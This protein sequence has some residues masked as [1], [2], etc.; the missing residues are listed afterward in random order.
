MI[1]LVLGAFLLLVVSGVAV[2]YA[3][4][5][6]SVLS[7]IATDN[8][9]YLAI[10]PQNFFS[11]IDVFA[12]MAMPL[13]ILTGE[14]MNRAGITKALID[15]AMAMM[16][17]IKGGLGHVNVLA[18]V[19]LSGIS[20]SAVA[21]AA[22]LGKTV[23]P[24]M[25][26]RGYSNLYASALTAAA[27][28]IGPIIPPSIIM[29]FYG[30][31]MQ[32]SVSAM[33]IGGVIPGLLL[34]FALFGANSYFAYRYNHPGGRRDELPRFWPSFLHAAP[35]LSLPAIILGGIVFGVVTPTEAAAL[36][37]VAAIVIGIYYGGLN[38]SELR[39]ALTQ[40]A[41]LTGTIF[42]ILGA[43]AAFGWLA[44]YLSLPQLLGSSVRDL[45]LGKW[46][47][48]VLI[49]IVFFVAGTFFEPPV[50]LALLVPLLG[51]QALALG[52]DPVHLGIILSLNLTL[53]MITP[54]LGGCLLVVSAVTQVDYWALSKAVLPFILVE[55][56]VL[57]FIIFVPELTLFLPREAGLIK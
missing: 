2:A 16:G 5:A 21:D 13:F 25:R 49:N 40:T 17:R 23:V 52:V 32:T 4:G 3:L 30:A 51:P 18:S 54:P 43:V 36:A 48:L 14:I 35:S 42:I 9:R 15:L 20:G 26:A 7:F 6:A 8:A 29:V 57:V 44:G 27:S 47:Y 39:D 45:S 53:G 1:W 41:S 10:L 46:E 11:Q 19:F 55:A 12:L 28:M 24:A 31:I 33:F 34:A 37:V 22:A 56:L 50:L 38:W